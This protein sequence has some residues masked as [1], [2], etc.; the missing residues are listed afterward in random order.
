MTPSQLLIQEANMLG[1]TVSAHLPSQPFSSY[2]PQETRSLLLLGSTGGLFFEGFLRANQGDPDPLDT[3][4]RE[5]ITR[6][7]TQFAPEALGVYFP[8]EAPFLPFQQFAAGL[9]A[10]GPLGILISA[11]YGPWFALRAC[12]ALKEEAP[13]PAPA[14]DVCASCPAP[15]ITACPAE[16]VQRAGLMVERCSAA[17]HCG[18]CQ[19]RCIAREACPVGVR[20]RYPDEA[21]RFHHRGATIFFPKG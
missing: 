19:E 11:E 9:G 14:P 12:V 8:F 20:W 18:P 4:T 21:I 13:L 3:Y 10:A 6:L 15:C 1:L 7:V 17:R 16:A 5:S 2:F